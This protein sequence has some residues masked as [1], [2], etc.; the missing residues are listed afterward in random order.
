[1]TIDRL[2]MTVP[3]Q[4]RHVRH[5]FKV[6]CLAVGFSSGLCLSQPPSGV[7]NATVRLEPH[8]GQTAFKIGDPVIVDLV[9][10]SRS[11]GAVVKT[12]NNPVR[13]LSDGIDVSPDGGWVRTHDTLRGQSTDGN[14][15]ASLSSD[16]IRVPV[17]LN[18]TITFLKPGHYEVTVTTERLRNSSDI[19]RTTPLED[20]EPCRKTN[21]V[22]IDISEMDSS[23]ESAL[24]ASLSRELDN[25]SEPVKIKPTPEAQALLAQAEE[26]LTQHP[27]DQDPEKL[28]ALT[29]KLGKLATEQIA[30][31]QKRADDR[32]ATAVRLACLEGDDA[33]RAKVHFIATEEDHADP[34][35][36]IAWIL[37]D[38][39][40]SSRNKQLQLDLLEDAWR[41]PHLLPTYPLQSA[42]EITPGRAGG[43]IW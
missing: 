41:N 33:L 4:I 30:S 28:K 10:T 20:C 3:G 18:R 5:L 29:Q 34:N 26:Q 19:L 22:G 25:T 1:M 40:A 27:S 8:E 37:I 21:S 32:H 13:P 38:G 17:L 12:D 9:F 43:F 24:V 2:Q 7:H 14:S 11:P 35:I 36:S 42:R 39:L 16:P 15:L 31:I 23:E 6:S